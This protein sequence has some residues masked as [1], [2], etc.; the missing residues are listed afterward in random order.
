MIVTVVG[1]WHKADN[2]IALNHCTLSG[3]KRTSVGP[4]SQPH[5][6]SEK[7]SNKQTAAAA[8]A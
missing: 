4:D 3:V 1:D 8:A 7:P 2:T 5:P 6:A